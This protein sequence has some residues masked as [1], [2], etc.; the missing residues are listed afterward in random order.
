MKS[1]KSLNNRRKYL[2]YC[3]CG[4]IIGLLNG[5]FGG[6]GG[7]IAVP[8]FENVLHFE[9]KKSHASAILVIL[10]LCAVSITTYLIAGSFN[11]SGGIFISIGVVIGGVIGALL[12]EKL[13]NKIIGYLF[14]VLMIISGIKLVL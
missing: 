12:L 5:F 6:G 11:F 4:I 7:M 10:P 14:A 13:N 3:T 9:T 2:L 1:T 8:L